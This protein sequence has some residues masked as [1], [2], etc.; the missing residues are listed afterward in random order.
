M[1]EAHRLEV[2]GTGRGGARPEG[3][4]GRISGAGRQGQRHAS[5]EGCASG[6]VDGTRG[7]RRRGAAGPEEGGSAQYDTGEEKS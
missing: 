3:N 5:V 2:Y 6:D 4:A 1:T 7:G